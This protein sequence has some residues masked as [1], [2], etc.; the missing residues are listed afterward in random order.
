MRRLLLALAWMSLVS[1]ACGD[2]DRDLPREYRAMAVPADRL[3]S[4]DAVTRGGE[5]FQKYCTLCHGV[6]GDGQG[7]QR[8]G[9]KPP[10]RDFTDPAWRQRTSPRRVY[11]AIREGVATTAM[12]SWKSL[13]EQDDWDLTAYVLSL[14]PR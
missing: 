3:A 11:F 12:P 7:L 14:A 5:L 10:P 13:T 9:L 2:A 6:R 1:S 4:P 8:E